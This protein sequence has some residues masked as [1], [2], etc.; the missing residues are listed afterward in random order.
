[1]FDWLQ[2]LTPPSNVTGPVLVAY[3]L[4]DIFLIV[5][6]ARLLGS[7]MARLHQ[8]RVVGEIL[9]GVLIGPTLLGPT[10][11]QVIA[12][13]EVRPILNAIATLALI[14]FM[15][16]AGVEY[17]PSSVK[18]RG[19]QAGLLALLA[20]AIPAILG[21]PLA[22][23][24]HSPEFAG[25]NG[26]DALPFALFL[27]ASLS[28]TAFPVMAHI[29]MER[30][31]LNS[32]LGAL[33]VATTG[34]MSV[35][36]FLY[37]AFA[38]TVA[39]ASSFRGL[40]VML[41][42]VVLFGVVSW[43]VVR[44]LIL[45]VMDRLSPNHEVNGNASALVFCGMV[46][47]GL[48]AHLIGINALVGGFLWGLVL[49]PNRQLRQLIAG[50][51]RDIAMVFLLPVFYSIA[52]FSTDLKLLSVDIIPVTL[53]VLLLAVAGKYAAA[54]PARTFGLSWRDTIKLGALFNTRGLLVLVVGL[55]GLQREIITPLMRAQP[56]SPT[57]KRRA[58]KGIA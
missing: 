53:L 33:G 54:L 44:P 47:Y 4:F 43:W 19:S 24:M 25:P 11:S 35:L 16:L 9:A 8:P 41:V 40:L 3:V 20:V 29:L 42:W 22:M 23:V 10:L 57:G 18:G 38:A 5:M 12:P 32:P 49:P 48:I 1:M 52:G 46:L 51:V 56:V 37:I 28:V 58:S 45:R 31:E 50:R 17:D 26:H 39:A 34:M 30:G 27:G 6:L 7:L 21:F 36:M 2:T 15:F 14:L 13:L 55:I